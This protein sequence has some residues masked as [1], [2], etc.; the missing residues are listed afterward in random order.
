M[1]SINIRFCEEMLKEVGERLCRISKREERASTAEGLFKQFKE[2]NDWAGGHIRNAL[3]EKYPHIPWSE[4]EFDVQTRMSQ[5]TRGSIGYATRLMGRC[6]FYKEF[7]LT[8][9]IY[10]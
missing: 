4:S 1:T 5:S 2:S 8:P 6:R 9:F 3:A 7:H 10:V